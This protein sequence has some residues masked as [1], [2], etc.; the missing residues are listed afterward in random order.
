MAGPEDA[1]ERRCELTYRRQTCSPSSSTLRIPVLILAEIDLLKRLLTCRFREESNQ[2][3]PCL[4]SSLRFGRSMTHSKQAIGCT[5]VALLS[6]TRRF[7]PIPIDE[8]LHRYR[9]S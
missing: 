2:A 8:S 9:V 6:S 5:I 3:A 7:T 4:S 1:G